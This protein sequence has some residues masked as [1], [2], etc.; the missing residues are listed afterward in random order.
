MTEAINRQPNLYSLL[1]ESKG[2]DFSKADELIQQN[3]YV[4]FKADRGM[5]TLHL[6]CEEG[7]SMACAY[8]IF[9][10]LRYGVH[11]GG[12][13]DKDADGSTPLEMLA[14]DGESMNNL[15][16]FIAA[17]CPLLFDSAN[18]TSAIIL[19]AIL[20]NDHN[21]P[22]MVRI[23]N[24][25]RE[26]PAALEADENENRASLLDRYCAGV[27]GAPD[28]HIMG[29]LIQEGIMIDS[30]PNGGLTLKDS[31]GMTPLSHILRTLFRDDGN[32]HGHGGLWDC[33]D[34]CV[35]LV[36]IAVVA[37]EFIVSFPTT[38]NILS[39][40]HLSRVA[41]LQDRYTDALDALSG[42]A[43]FLLYEAFEKVCL[44]PFSM[45]E[46]KAYYSELYRLCF[47]GHL[48]AGAGG[49]TITLGGTTTSLFY[50]A[51]GRG[52]PWSRGLKFI[53]E[54]NKKAIL[55]KDREY[56]LPASLFA[57]NV[58][59]DIDTIYELLRRDIGLFDG[60]A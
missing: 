52:L 49:I 47:R 55:R 42:D 25:I 9:H 43:R 57:A 58:G 4:L 39:M 54:A 27:I 12:L 5:T 33:V 10:S 2:I 11:C 30:L 8:L 22:C 48:P 3:P 59:Q 35:R 44:L 29:M 51:A 15:C 56:G 60:R 21:D 14:R 34:T 19:E 53:A 46:N 37:A 50:F 24:V 26:H 7:W 32:G 41:L 45:D 40:M 20:H 1:I 23:V 6:L 16:S 28:P 36:G 38:M 17:S 18:F 31:S 13:L